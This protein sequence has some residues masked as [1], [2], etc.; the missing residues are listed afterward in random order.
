MINIQF[1]TGFQSYHPYVNILYFF[2]VGVLAMYVNHPIFLLTGLIVI[3]LTTLALGGKSQLKT[4]TPLITIMAFIMI[5]LNPFLV[6]RG[7]NILFYFRGKQVTLEATMYGFVMALS[8]VTILLM[9][10]SFNIVLN[11]NKFLFIFSR[12]LPRT[13]FLIMLTLRFMPLLKERYEEIDM[14]QRLKGM[15]LAHGSLFKRMKNGLT[16][17]QILLAWSLEEALQTAD[18]MK[19]RGYG[20]GK[21][22]SYIPY[23]MQARDWMSI[24]YLTLLFSLCLFS[25]YLGYGK[26][27]IYPELGTLQFFALDWVS[28]FS[29]ILLFSFPLH[30]EGREKLRWTFSR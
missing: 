20:T 24:L 11:G 29:M 26:I 4:W 3:I 21:T 25:G 30:I 14:A 9:F 2:F 10:I 1:G 8:I 5:V 22:S 17:V 27:V 15:T 7:T 28:F 23:N 13:A 18:A 16:F 6:S 12:I 19:A